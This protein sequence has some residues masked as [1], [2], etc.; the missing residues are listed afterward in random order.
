MWEQPHSFDPG[1]NPELDE[2]LD[3]AALVSEVAI[4]FGLPEDA[5]ESLIKKAI[6]KGT[7]CGAWIEFTVTGI[8]VGSIVEGSDVDCTSHALIWTGEED[9]GAWIDNALAEIEEE[10]NYIWKEWNEPF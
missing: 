6:F 4:H 10:A 5:E 2:E 3:G 9:V 1:D 7:N 8:A